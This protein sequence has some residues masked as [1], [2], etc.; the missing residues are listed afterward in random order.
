MPTGSSRCAMGMFLVRSWVRHEGNYAGAVGVYSCVFEQSVLISHTTYKR[1]SVLVSLTGDM[2]LLTLLVLI[3]LAYTDQLPRFEWKTAILGPPPGRQKIEVKT[4]TQSTSSS[5][6]IYHRVFIAAPRRVPDPLPSSEQVVIDAPPGV[7]GGTGENRTSILS[8]IVPIIEKPSV[9]A[10]VLQPPK[11]SNPSA[12]PI[13]VSI[14]VQMA[15]LVHQVIPVYPPMAKA[16]RISG[17]VHLVGVIGKEGRVEHLQLMSG[18]PIL[19]KAAMDA[20]QQ[21]I[22]RP[23]LLS[24]E[25]VEVTAPIDVFFTL[26]Q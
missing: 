22:Y 23:T 13:R 7:I 4:V 8:G 10:P 3:P 15:K 24:G 5:P 9:A 1:W 12:A 16:M 11:Q 14:G 21:W 2:A 18:H 26:T 25:P 20:V 6:S 19:A 17:V